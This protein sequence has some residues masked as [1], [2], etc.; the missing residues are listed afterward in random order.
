MKID[1]GQ[2]APPRCAHGTHRVQR[3]PKSGAG[4]RVGTN[5]I[6]SVSGFEITILGRLFSNFM[7]NSIG[8]VIFFVI[9]HVLF[10]RYLVP[11]RT[12]PPLQ[13][14]FQILPQAQRLIENKFHSNNLQNRCQNVSC[15]PTQILIERHQNYFLQNC[16]GNV[17]G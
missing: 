5:K 6:K 15:T 7:Q 3:T 1:G 13:I 4:S 2:P 10:P 11:T 8:F 9:F 16:L 17:H 14:L 12:A